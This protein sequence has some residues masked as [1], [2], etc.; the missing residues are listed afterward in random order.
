MMITITL[1]ELW[2][3]EVVAGVEPHTGWQASA[4]LL[5][6]ISGEQ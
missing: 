1:D 6:M 5:F 4:Q 2:I 3:V